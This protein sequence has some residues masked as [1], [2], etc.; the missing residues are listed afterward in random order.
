[1]Y[2]YVYLLTPSNLCSNPMKYILLLSQF[3]T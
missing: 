2:M 1:M 3:Y